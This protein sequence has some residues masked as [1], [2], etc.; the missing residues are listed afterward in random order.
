MLEGCVLEGLGGTVYMNP[1]F[2]HVCS[3]DPH[4]AVQDF[5]IALLIGNSETNKSALAYLH[6]GV[7]YSQLKR[8]AKIVCIIIMMN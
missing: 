5:S 3:K 6:R 4:R 1:S 8:Y 2:I 7:V